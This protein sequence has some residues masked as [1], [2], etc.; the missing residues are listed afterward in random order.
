MKIALGE[1]LPRAP[2]GMGSI[3]AAFVEIGTPFLSAHFSE[4]ADVRLEE[5]EGQ[6]KPQVPDDR[7][8]YFGLDALGQVVVQED[9]PEFFEGEGR[10]SPHTTFDSRRVVD[11]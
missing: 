9:L 8:A 10:A 11:I 7:V 2:V 1:G 5:G 4:E 3:I 6:R